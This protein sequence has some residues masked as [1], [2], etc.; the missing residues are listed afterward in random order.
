[1]VLLLD[2]RGE[3]VLEGG[4]IEEQMLRLAEL[5][6]RPVDPRAR[7]D[8]VDGVELATA[9]VALVAA[10][11]VVA[12]MRACPLDVAVGER[13]AGGGRERAE[14]GL[15]DD[16]AFLVQG[17]EHVLND[18]VVILRRRAREKVVREPKIPQVVPD[19]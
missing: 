19:D 3:L 13:V 16:E 6:R 11:A 14:G 18:A 9:V 1:V 2:P 8:Q 5:G 4:E 10:R 12:A 7:V 15:L 17:S